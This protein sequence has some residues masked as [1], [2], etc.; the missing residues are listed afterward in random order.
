MM[1]AYEQA[2]MMAEVEGLFWP[3]D[4]FRGWQWRTTGWQW[5]LCSHCAGMPAIWL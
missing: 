5:Q 2:R 1:K 4:G 3:V